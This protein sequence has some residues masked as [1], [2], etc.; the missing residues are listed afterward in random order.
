MVDVKYYRY[1]ASVWEFADKHERYVSAS[2]VAE[3]HQ[4]IAQSVH[5]SGICNCKCNARTRTEPLQ[6]DHHATLCLSRISHT[7]WHLRC[8][9]PFLP[10]EISSFYPNSHPITH[11]VISKT[12]SALEAFAIVYLKEIRFMISKKGNL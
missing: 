4:C 8:L 3:C 11:F 2:Q 5:F 7:K 10:Y 1:R 12:A 6:T 9:Y